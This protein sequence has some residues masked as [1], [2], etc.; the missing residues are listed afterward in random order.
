MPAELYLDDDLFREERLYN[1][2]MDILLTEHKTMLK[3][4][5]D[6]YKKSPAR[7]KHLPM[8]RFLDL[9]TDCDVSNPAVRVPMQVF[10]RQISRWQRTRRGRVVSTTSAPIMAPDPDPDRTRVIPRTRHDPLSW[11]P[12]KARPTCP[13]NPPRPPP[14]HSPV[15][16]R[17]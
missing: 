2:Q 9:L 1:Q 16:G 5:Y 10:S 12:F 7:P 13:F 17:R 15:R 6:Y 3:L 8:Q 14:L 4:V 11:T